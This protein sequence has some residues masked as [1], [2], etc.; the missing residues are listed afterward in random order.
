MPRVSANINT[1]L[2]AANNAAARTALG[3]AASAANL[4][5]VTIA[6]SGIDYTGTTDSTAAIETLMSDAITAGIYEGRCLGGTLKCNLTIPAS[7][8][9]LGM[10]T[11]L[12]GEDPPLQIATKLIPQDDTDPVIYLATAASQVVSGF[13]I[14]SSAIGIKVGNDAVF[15]GISAKF[16]RIRVYDCT[17]GV[18]VNFAVGIIFEHVHCNWG[19]KGWQFSAGGVNPV[20]T[21]QLISCGA[22]FNTGTCIEANQ[23]RNLLI[24]GGEWGNG[25]GAFLDAQGGIG[26]IVINNANIESQNNDYLFIVTN[27]YLELNSVRIDVATANPDLVSFIRQPSGNAVISIRNPYWSIS[28]P[29]Y[30][31]EGVTTTKPPKV[32]GM[33]TGTFR[34]ATDN[35]FGTTLRLADVVDVSAEAYRTSNQ[36]GMTTGVTTVVTFS[37]ED[38]DTSSNFDPATGLFTIPSPGVY[39]L[40]CGLILNASNTGFTRVIERKNGSDGKILH[41]LYNH[42]Q[43]EGLTGSKTQRLDAGNT[44]GIGINHDKG[45]DMSLYATG[46]ANECWISIVKVSD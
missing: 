29:G 32:S 24:Q 17:I 28:T 33:N 1:F 5:F 38:H 27:A 22:N 37:A 2:G 41:T 9:L 46:A 21:S 6:G 31:W 36:T 3:F 8:R 14:E 18:Q 12:D 10:G 19:G 16:E 15:A 23:V 11:A 45:S 43:Y 25:T 13:E 44:L 34:F 42:P 26:H 20:D 40:S 7:F 35:T 4:P 39:T 30:I